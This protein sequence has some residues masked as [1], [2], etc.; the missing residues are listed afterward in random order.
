[1]V[2]MNLEICAPTQNIVYMNNWDMCTR[3]RTWYTWTLKICAPTQKM[4]HMNLEICAPTQNI[5]YMNNWDMCTRHRTCTHEPQD[6][7]TKH[8]MVHMNNWDMCTKH[9]TWYIW[10]LEIYVSTTE[11]VHMNTSDICAPSTHKPQDSGMQRK[12]LYTWRLKICTPNSEQCTHEPY[13]MC[14]EYRT[15][16]TWP[17]KHWVI[18]QEMTG[19]CIKHNGQFRYLHHEAHN[20]LNHME[21]ALH[22]DGWCSVE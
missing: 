12:T 8:G 16:Y 2:H 11:H 17:Y 19:K 22:I 21:E 6:M 5:V 13:N 1:M 20:H 14:T 18:F 10:T 15:W 4:V 7:C 3:H 9:R